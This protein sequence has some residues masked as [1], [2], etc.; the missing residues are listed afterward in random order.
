MQFGN[1]KI[2]YS[3]HTNICTKI[4]KFDSKYSCSHCLCTNTA[5]WKL[6]KHN[7]KKHNAVIISAASEKKNLLTKECESKVCVTCKRTYKATIDAI[8]YHTR[9]CALAI[10]DIC[11]FES[12]YQIPHKPQHFKRH[13][14]PRGIKLHL[15]REHQKPKIIFKCC[16]C[17]LTFKT[18]RM[19]FVHEEKHKLRRKSPLCNLFFLPNICI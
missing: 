2:K 15:L 17:S 19:Q 16:Y 9:W 18:K 14:I 1:N 12:P 4:R 7:L 13:F 8:Y 5:F 3:T 6:K 10:C 11:N